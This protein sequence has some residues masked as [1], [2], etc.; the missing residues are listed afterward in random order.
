MTAAQRLKSRL[1]LVR[2]LLSHPTARS[3]PGRPV[4]RFIGWQLLKRSGM[5]PITI[6]AFGGSRLC[7][8]PKS[9]SSNAVIYYDW[10]DW[11]ELSLIAAALR[12]SDSFVDVGANVGVYSALA[13]SRLAPNGRVMAFEPDPD[14]VGW[15]RETFALNGFPLHDVHQLALGESSGSCSFLSGRGPRSAVASTRAPDAS[16]A[17]DERTLSMARLDEVLPPESS[18]PRRL[19]FGK[20]DVEGFELSVL[21]GAEGLLAR[22]APP[23]WL[24]ETNARSH[25]YGSSRAE[26]HALLAGYGY[27][28]FEVLGDGTTLRPVPEGGPYPRNALAVGD[29]S[30]LRERVPGLSFG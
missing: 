25:D 8:P 6:R 27:E 17:L 26:V 20:I 11:A 18:E 7:C 21:R 10:P 19:A 24:L 16:S 13:M 29:R 14:N 1:R 2:T 12:P 5:G 23:C 9:P 15:L 30:W 22:S 28:L 3:H 4:A